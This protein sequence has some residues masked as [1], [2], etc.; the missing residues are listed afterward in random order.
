MD[1]AFGI[2]VIVYFVKFLKIDHNI[3]GICVI[4]WKYSYWFQ[5]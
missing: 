3:M 1:I 4:Y 5:L 2:L